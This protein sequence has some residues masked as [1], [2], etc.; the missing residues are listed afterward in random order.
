VNQANAEKINGLSWDGH[1]LA[2]I[3]GMSVVSKQSFMMNYTSLVYQ[4]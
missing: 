4:T 1:E 3:V 2:E